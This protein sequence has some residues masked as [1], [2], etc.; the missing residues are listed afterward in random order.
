MAR[1]P[2]PVLAV[3]ALLAACSEPRRPASS[4]DGRPRLREARST[5]GDVSI[6]LPEDLVVHAF[7][8]A[9]AGTA[10]DGSL[11]VFVERLAETDPLRAAGPAKDALV[12]L[13][14]TV[15]D[16][17][18]FERAIAVRLSRGGTEA[19]PAERREAWWIDRDGAVLVCD[20]VA[21]P[22]GFDRLGDPLRR[23][24][25]GATSPAPPGR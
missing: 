7:A 8:G 25:Q 13:G 10:P 16:E 9:V 2:L 1:V 11:R 6:A 20:A 3:I 12:S 18:H 24:C 23:L 15:R 21:R 22:E 14:W 17:Q 19:K 5:G 4:A